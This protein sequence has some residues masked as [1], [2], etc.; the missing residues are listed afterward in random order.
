[1]G[2]TY[3]TVAKAEGKQQVVLNGNTYKKWSDSS[4]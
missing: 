1:M 2:V 4:E 3:A